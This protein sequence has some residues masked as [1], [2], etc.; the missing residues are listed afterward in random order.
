MSF[1]IRN[2]PSISPP[3][4]LKE[5]STQVY[6]IQS[7]TILKIG[8]AA[9]AC[10]LLSYAIY[11]A[12]SFLTRLSANSVKQNINMDDYLKKK[13]QSCQATKNFYELAENELKACNGLPLKVK[14][15][16]P[17]HSAF[18]QQDKAFCSWPKGEILINSALNK[19]RAF[20]FFLFELAN[21]T[22]CAKFREIHQRAILGELSREEY[23]FEM[24]NTEYI[25]IMI[26]ST[27]VKDAVAE[28]GE[29]WKK[30]DFYHHHV[31]NPVQYFN[32]AIQSGHTAYYLKSWDKFYKPL[33]KKTNF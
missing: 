4:F 10:L 31:I 14:L 33:I 29:D 25:S 30:Y 1:S 24:E 28:K 23:A 27:I 19:D 21:M 16:P 32:V 18:K 11:R 12:I 5:A 9:L 22:Q 17:T 7:K 13:I 26:H 6:S 2:L 3:S 8:L 15:L 20:G